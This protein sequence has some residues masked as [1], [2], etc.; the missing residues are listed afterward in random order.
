M[1]ADLL[2][3]SVMRRWCLL[4][5]C[6]SVMIALG[7]CS[8]DSTGPDNPGS[9]YGSG[10]IVTETRALEDFSSLRVEMAATVTVELAD[11]QSVIVSVDDNILEYVETVMRADTLVIR[12][13]DDAQ[14]TD[15]DLDIALEM[16]DLDALLCPG[17]GTI[18]SVSEIEVD[19][20]RV[21]IPGIGTVV[22][23]LTVD[24]LETLVPGFGTLDYT[25]TA[26]QHTIS[27]SGTGTV[28]A[29]NL[30]TADCNIG[31]SGSGSALVTAINTLNVSISGAGTVY[32]KGNPAITDT[33]SGD[34]QIIDAN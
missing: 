5:L 12:T 20:L 31:I 6:V 10:D 2:K 23:D 18:R 7:A 4:L 19:A 16:T 14:L 25:G 22:L 11:S 15:Y 34:G 27:I 13:R 9:I 29:Y 21:S 33:I 32:Y 1:S 24:R 28:S 17:V 26:A 3:D 30:A 8:E